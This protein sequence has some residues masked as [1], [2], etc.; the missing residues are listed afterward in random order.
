MLVSVLSLLHF[1][2]T[3]MSS[4]TLN[5]I[6]ALLC[7]HYIFFSLFSWG[8]KLLCFFIYLAFF[9]YIMHSSHTSNCFSVQFCTWSFQYLPIYW[10]S[11]KLGGWYLHRMHNYNF[12]IFLCYHSWNFSLPF[13]LVGLP[14]SRILFLLFLFVCLFDSFNTSHHSIVSS[15]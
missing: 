6:R 14:F 11:R 15:N 7:L 4:F 3:L 1:Q 8:Y 12:G 13:I 2:E 10:F 9:I 5:I